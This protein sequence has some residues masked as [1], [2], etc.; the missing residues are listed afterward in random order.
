MK[1]EVGD[2]DILVNNAGVMFVDDILSRSEEQISIT[3]DVNIL[4]HF[5]V[6]IG[7]LWMFCLFLFFLH[8]CPPVLGG[9]SS[10]ACMLLLD[11][12]SSPALEV[13]S[14]KDPVV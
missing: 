12:K 6:S 4:S 11:D 13:S 10:W 2:V 9:N 14:S 7:Y 5:W 1:S 3:F 8:F